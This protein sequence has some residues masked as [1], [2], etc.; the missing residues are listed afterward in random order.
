M[1]P[2][3]HIS[4]VVGRYVHRV[5]LQTVSYRNL[6]QL[7]WKNKKLELGKL[8]S[9]ISVRESNSPSIELNCT[10]GDDYYV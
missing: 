5:S 3:Q 10:Y 4:Y 9:P 2:F 1:I 6:Q 8:K 7:S